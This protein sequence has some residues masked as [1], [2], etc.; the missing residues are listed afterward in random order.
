MQIPAPPAVRGRNLGRGGN[1]CQETGC[2]NLT[3]P[4][5][6]RCKSS[7]A[8]CWMMFG[9][10]KCLLYF[11]WKTSK[12]SYRKGKI[13]RNGHSQFFSFILY[14][15]QLAT[16][17]SLL[18]GTSIFSLHLTLRPRRALR[19]DPDAPFLNVAGRTG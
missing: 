6:N 9:A 10:G 3:A 16:R 13:T 4:A 2:K 7:F 8:H 12:G 14:I 19:D 17:W 18:G 1:F 5:K 11:Y 15:R